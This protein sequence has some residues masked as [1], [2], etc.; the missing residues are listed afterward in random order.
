MIT[1]QELQGNWHE[2]KGKLREKFGQISDDEFEK[3]GGNVDQLVGMIE[4]RTGEA[5]RSIETFLDQLSH[6]GQSMAASAAGMAANAA[7][8]MRDYANQAGGAIKDGYEQV[9]T[10]F[11]EGVDSAQDMVR[12]KPVESVAIALGAGLVAGA[13]LGLLIGKSR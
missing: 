13:I 8:S 2:I 10:N 3:V 1:R 6:K 5:R 4:K 11:R 7:N 9:A 12:R